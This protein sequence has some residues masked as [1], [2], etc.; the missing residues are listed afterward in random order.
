MADL[1]TTKGKHH[2][3]FTEAKVKQ[4]EKN[5]MDLK[6]T[7]EQFINPFADRCDQ[8]INMATKAVLPEKIQEDIA[9]RTM[10]GEEMLVVANARYIDHKHSIGTYGF[11]VVSR[12]LFA[13]DSSL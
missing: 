4:Q 8:L 6:H 11:F 3:E 1:S 13:A 9:K 2:H 5:V 10:F 12:G 7:T